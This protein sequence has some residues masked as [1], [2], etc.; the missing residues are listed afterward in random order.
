MT[1]SAKTLFE[2]LES[3]DNS[4]I[5]FFSVGRL[6]KVPDQKSPCSSAYGKVSSNLKGYLTDSWVMASTYSEGVDY[7]NVILY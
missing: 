5:L 2:A 7:T 3:A 1:F 6:A 4:A